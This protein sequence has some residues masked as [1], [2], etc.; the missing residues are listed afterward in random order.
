MPVVNETLDLPGSGSPDVTVTVE[1]VGTGGYPVE[2]FHSAGD[3]TIVGKLTPTVTAGAW[4]ATLVA[5]SLIVPSGTV[6][7]RTVTG[8]GFGAS[9]YFS[10]PAGGGPYV[11]EDLL[12]DVPGAI[13]PTALAALAARVTALEASALLIDP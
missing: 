6:Y 2:G 11:F 9:D 1:L 10:V 3:V 7:R 12:V 8:R 4:T 5:N 13:E